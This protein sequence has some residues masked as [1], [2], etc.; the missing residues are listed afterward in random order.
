MLSENL[1]ILIGEVVKPPFV[2]KIKDKE[3]VFL[4]L[5]TA[6]PV[7][8]K[9][10][11]FIAKDYHR[12]WLPSEWMIN[13]Y[14]GLKKGETIR[15]FGRLSILRKTYFYEYKGERKSARF[16]DATT[17]PISIAIIPKEEISDVKDYDDYTKEI[18]DKE[19]VE[20]KIPKK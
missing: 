10:G 19:K 15:V 1:Q 14:K 12:I 9:D 16:N 13:A 7:I 2:T 11:Y 4:Y 3:K 18:T 20:F 8:K 5:V 17:I 6:V